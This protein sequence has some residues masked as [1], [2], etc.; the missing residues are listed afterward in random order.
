MANRM[1]AA[2]LWGLFWLLI[3]GVMQGAF[4][5]PMKF[6]RNWKW[7]HLWLWYALLAFFVLPLAMAIAT[8]PRWG[9]VYNDVPAAA[10]AQ[11]ATFGLAWGAGSVLYGLGIDALGMT[12][13]YPI[14]TA[15][16]TAL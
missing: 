5:L 2:Y 11:T 1:T 14:M 4:P 3:A 8:V 7:E 15:L 13:G 6:T 9:S 16:T 10:L 12:L